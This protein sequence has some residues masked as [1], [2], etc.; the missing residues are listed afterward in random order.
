MKLT[1]EKKSP[2]GVQF[3]G[4]WYNKS[5]YDEVNLDSLVVGQEIDAVISGDKY[6][7][8]YTLT[9]N[10]MSPT[11]KS[12]TVAQTASKPSSD[13]QRI[14]E[15]VVSTVLASDLPSDSFDALITKYTGY[16]LTGKF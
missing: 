11:P 4:K 8:S 1:V 6:I 5:K 7:K 15:L 10:V 2:Y 14:R 16:I 13:E 3:E 12:E 9:G